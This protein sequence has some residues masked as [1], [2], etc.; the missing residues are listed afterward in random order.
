LLS[1][2]ECLEIKYVQFLLFLS[3]HSQPQYLK[4]WLKRAEEQQIFVVFI[5]VD[6]QHSGSS[7]LKMPSVGR[8]LDGNITMGSYIGMSFYVSLQWSHELDS[9]PFPYYVILRNISNLPQVLADAL[10]QWF[11]AVNQKDS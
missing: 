7:I 9:F 8:D 10:R 6:T 5:V 3:S 4:Q 11:E 2:T 1:L